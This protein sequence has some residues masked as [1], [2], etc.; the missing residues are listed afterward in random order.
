M[1]NA[2]EL[3]EAGQG[4]KVL[5]VEDDL[6]LRENTTRLLNSFFSEV[7]P[8]ENGQVGLDIY[9]EGSYD[10]VITDINMPVMSG[11]R[12]SKVIKESNKKQVIIVI[13]AHDE[14]KYLLDLINM[15]VDNFILKPLDI[16]QFFEVLHKAISLVRFAKMEEEY[17]QKLEET[18]E[19]RTQELQ[20]A[21]SLVQE[22]S[23]EV[24]QRLTAATE[25]RDSETGLH[26]R[27]LG[28]FAPTLARAMGLSD[29]FVESLAFAAPLHDIGKIG[30]LDKILLKPGPLTREEYEIMKTHTITG[31][32]ILSDSIHEK[33]NVTASIALSHHERWDGSG[34]PYGLK[35]EDIPLEGRIV[36]ICDHYDA[37]R[38]KRPYKPALSHQEAMKIIVNGDMKSSPGCFDPQIL[39]VF[40]RIADEFDQIYVS[41]HD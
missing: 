31:A 28:L 3:R 7:T 29:E 5:Y 41:Q 11:V 18:V 6:D 14:A 37:L 4:L 2:K 34:Y 12:L 15:G 16:G 30:I 39:E 24:V 22:L 32:S 33:I 20:E 13:S 21:L 38:S 19:I 10:I 27:R 25:L 8:A 17:K 26:N 40:I 35:G 1:V 36:S 23:G 9:R